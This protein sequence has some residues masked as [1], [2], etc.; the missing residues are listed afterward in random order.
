MGEHKNIRPLHEPLRRAGIQNPGEI[1]IADPVQQVLLADDTR[2]LVRPLMAPQVMIGAFVTAAAGLRAA[3]EVHVIAQGGTWF[4]DL[5]HNATAG[6]TIFSGVVTVGGLGAPVLPT[7]VNASVFGE[8]TPQNTVALGDTATAFPSPLGWQD[9]FSGGSPFH[10]RLNPA[11]WLPPGAFFVM[12]RVSLAAATTLSF[13]YQEI[14]G[15][16]DVP[17]A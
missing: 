5:G 1:L 9:F 15:R 17:V 10:Q 16:S 3:A 8:G 14:P 12:M 6:I 4:Y 7:R 13:T 2:H 11:I